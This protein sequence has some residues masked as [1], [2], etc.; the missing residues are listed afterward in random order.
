[1][2]VSKSGEAVDEVPIELVG[3]GLGD[4]VV[5]VGGGDADTDSVGAENIYS[6]TIDSAPRPGVL[7]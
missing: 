2:E 7:P 5:R 1:M 6:D 4:V 3:V